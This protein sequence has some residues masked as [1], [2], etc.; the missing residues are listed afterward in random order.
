MVSYFLA[1]AWGICL[2]ISFI[3][4]GGAINRILF[5][6]DRIDWGQKATWGIAWSVV[7]G[8]VL[9]VTWTISPATILIYIGLGVLYGII[10]V[11]VQRNSI[12][13]TLNWIIN[14]WQQN[15][16]FAIGSSIALL[17]TVWQ[18]AGCVYSYTFSIVDDYSAYFVFPEKMLQKR[19]HK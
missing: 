15:K 9:N 19:R 5:P 7:F 14:V 2:L 12:A 11:W 13:A 17:L 16:L 1:F 18:Y 4:W 8:G 3:G 10:D 6:E